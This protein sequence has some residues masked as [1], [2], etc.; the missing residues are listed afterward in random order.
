MAPNAVQDLDASNQVTPNERQS[1][2]YSLKEVSK[3]DVPEDCWLV[4]DSKVYNVT[5][6]IP[7]HPGGSLI[8][9]KAGQDSTY[10]FNSYHPLYV[11][12]LLDRYCIGEVE[13]IPSDEQLNMS[14]VL[15]QDSCQEA[16]YLTLK[17]RVEAYF[18]K[19]KV[20]P[21]VHP[22]MFIKSLLV[23]AGFVLCYYLTFFRLQSFAW[24]SISAIGMGFFIAEVGMSIQHD[25]NHGAYSNW[26][27][28]GYIMGASLDVI[29][30]SSFM[31]RQQHVVGHHSHTNVNNYDPDI[32]V[33][34]PDLRCVSS[35]QPRHSYH[36]Y[37]HLYLGPLYGLLALKSIFIDDFAAY[38]SGS[39]GQVTIP[40]M[41]PL[42]FKIFWGG[43]IFYGLY[44]I[45]I[46]LLFSNLHW[47]SFLL[48]FMLSQLVTGW[49]LALF[50]Q[51]AHVV[52]EAAFLNVDFSKG[53]PMLPSGWAAMQV[54]TTSNFSPNSL[55]WTH[56]SGGLNYQI[57]HHL[58]PAVCHLH[59]PGIQPI[60]EATC[61]EFNI[62]Y[63]CFPSFFEALK[64]HFRYLRKVGYKDMELRLVG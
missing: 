9:L 46:P 29:G 44:M 30:A 10:L 5:S 16:F 17:E 26:P 52:E 62:P 6:W 2:K 53:F 7:S 23:I 25:S 13:R 45:A 54:Y 33:K 47:S 21:R 20:N 4:I 43:K 39:I 59:Y 14:T 15:Y 35:S 50:F 1:K 31:W 22:H 3:H 37:Q 58:F 32:R 19:K 41:T 12:K 48:L 24:S 38:F 8:H 42:E 40:K 51:V 18:E 56:I 27:L 60:V 28:L 64:C 63:N 57:E 34:D 49:I 55:L 36:T 11:R 61:R